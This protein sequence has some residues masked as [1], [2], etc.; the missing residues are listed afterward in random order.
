MSRNINSAPKKVFIPYFMGGLGHINQAESIAHCLHQKAPD[1]EIRL[2]DP[3]E[4]LQERSLNA[5]YSELWKTFL[6]NPVAANF[7]FNFDKVF[8]QVGSFINFQGLKPAIPKAMGFLSGYRPDLIMSC[9]WG[10][11]HLFDLARKALGIEVPLFYVYGELAGSYKLINCGADIYFTET[12][13]AYQ[14][15]LEIGIRPEQ[16]EIINLIVHPRFYSL[17]V[18]KEE[19]RLRMGLAKDLYT[20]VVSLGGEGI[21]FS[22]EF[23]AEF[24]NGVK[25]AQMVILTGLNKELFEALSREIK[26]ERIT[27]HGYLE[28][29][30]MVLV[31]V[32]AD[33]MA[34]KCGTLTICEAIKKGIPYIVTRIGAPNERAN[35][36]YLISKGFGW[37]EPKPALFARLINE[38]IADPTLYNDALKRLSEVPRTNGA[39]DIAS[40]IVSRIGQ[41][42]ARESVRI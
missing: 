39:E 35:M 16:V 12:E 36:E 9:H 10:C 27:V 26:N 24:L 40:Y 38:L 7:V 2:S 29:E 11:T 33:I 22:L 15:L 30:K 5:L 6:K 23:V 41:Y 3:A 8:P 18:S 37:Y 31:K 4:D 42:S 1:L 19:A 32:A 13:E 20:L 14:G 28:V 21:G 17:G 34:G 25:N